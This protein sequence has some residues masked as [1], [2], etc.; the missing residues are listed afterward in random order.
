MNDMMFAYIG[1]ILS[2]RN[3]PSVE[4]NQYSSDTQKISIILKNIKTK[5]DAL[6]NMKHDDWFVRDFCEYVLT[7]DIEL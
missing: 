5:N 1:N 6:L 4:Y 3:I 7:G 2:V